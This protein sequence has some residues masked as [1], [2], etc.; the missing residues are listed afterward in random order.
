MTLETTSGVPPRIPGHGTGAG[1]GA[2]ALSPP[3]RLKTNKEVGQWHALIRL[4]K[5][6]RTEAESKPPANRRCHPIRLCVVGLLLSH[7][8][9]GNG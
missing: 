4:C 9:K 2:S 1:K 3:L 6:A 5:Q 8:V 7:I